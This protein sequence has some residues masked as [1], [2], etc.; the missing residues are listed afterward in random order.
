MTPLGECIPAKELVLAGHQD[1]T[2]SLGMVASDRFGNSIRTR[3]LTY[4]GNMYQGTTWKVPKSYDCGTLQGKHE[5]EKIW[6]LDPTAGLGVA[7]QDF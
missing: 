6:R 7:I 1:V 4:L 5:H 2:T 3:L